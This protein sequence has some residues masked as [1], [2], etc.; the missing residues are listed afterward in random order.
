M[1]LDGKEQESQGL[2]YN[3]HS[4]TSESVKKYGRCLDSLFS[5][6]CVSEYMN[7]QHIAR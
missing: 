4:G 6:D 5:G 3:Q 1:S 7:E 2:P